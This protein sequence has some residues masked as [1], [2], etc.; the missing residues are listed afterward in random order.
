L[1]FNRFVVVE[2]LRYLLKDVPP[3]TPVWYGCN[4]RRSYTHEYMSGGA[5]EIYL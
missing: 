1:F 3:T 2:N 4:F 5:G